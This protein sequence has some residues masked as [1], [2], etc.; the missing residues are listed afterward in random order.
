MG[1]RDAIL[2]KPRESSGASSANRIDFQKSWALCRLFELH[3]SNKDY[4][5]ILEQHEDVVVFFFDPAGSESAE[6][7]QI[8]TRALHLKRWGLPELLK[9]EKK[10]VPGTGKPKTKTSPAVKAQKV[11]GLSILGKMYQN[12]M[13]LG[14]DVASVN[15]VTNTSYTITL[16]GGASCAGRNSFCLNEL[17]P[18]D[19]A[20]INAKVAAEHSLGAPVNDLADRT[21]LR[22]SDLSLLEHS[23]H[24]SGKCGEFLEKQKPG[25]AYAV[26][27]V[28]RMLAEEVRRRAD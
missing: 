14:V 26:P 13:V 20:D 27:A 5:L 22:I 12:C 15:F 10:A 21:H 3:E 17:D 9:R 7:F 6:C 24:A 28:Y 8:K 18:T 1:L 11:P 2:T 16:N 19:I 25:R 23:T 4:V